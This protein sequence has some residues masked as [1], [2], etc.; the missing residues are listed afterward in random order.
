[1]NFTFH[2]SKMAKKVPL[3]FNVFNRL[4]INDN[5]DM[6]LLPLWRWVIT[7]NVSN[8]LGNKNAIWFSRWMQTEA[9]ELI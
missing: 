5:K 1:M 8:L 9:L 4:S 6:Y 3:N 2:F 7:Q